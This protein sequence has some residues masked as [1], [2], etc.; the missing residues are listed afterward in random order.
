[1][2]NNNK[3]RL[4]LFITPAIAKHARAQAVLE[5][6]SLTALVEKALIKYLPKETVIRKA[7]DRA[8][9]RVDPDP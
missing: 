8:D 4:T 3:K 6:L 7:D 2:T 1:M 9:I 5:E